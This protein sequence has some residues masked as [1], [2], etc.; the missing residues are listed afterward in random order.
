MD[1][2]LPSMPEP[3]APSPAPHKLGVVVNI[4]NPR[5]QETEAANQKVK[6]I[7]SYLAK[8]TSTWDTQDPV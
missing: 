4:Y 2:C 3:W 5:T 8:V 1:E 7:L 6:N